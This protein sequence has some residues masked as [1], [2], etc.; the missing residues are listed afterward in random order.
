[1]NKNDID[2]T[3]AESISYP[4]MNEQIG[5]AIG[6][7]VVRFLQTALSHNLV[8][9]ADEVV[10][11]FRPVIL[12]MNVA[13]IAREYNNTISAYRPRGEEGERWDAMC[14][15]LEVFV[16]AEKMPE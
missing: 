3:A 7:Y 2:K 15:K 1:M 6:A 10:R 11:K 14:E 4:D 9:L 12:K 16:T 5:V 8:D 13:G